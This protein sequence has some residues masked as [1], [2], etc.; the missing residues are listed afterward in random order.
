[1]C[2][3]CR[4]VSTSLNTKKTSTTKR[5]K[6]INKL[7]TDKRERN[8]RMQRKTMDEKVTQD[9]DDESEL[10]STRRGCATNTELLGQ[11]YYAMTELYPS[12]EPDRK[13]CDKH[14]QEI[15][16]K[17]GEKHV[18][19]TSEFAKI[20]ADVEHGLVPF[21]MRG[22]GSRWLS[23]IQCLMIMLC[24][25]IVFIVCVAPI[26]FSLKHAVTGDS[27]KHDQFSVIGN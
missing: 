8:K 9:F 20:E 2:L 5:T 24:F 22:R 3:T 27:E 26:F 16:E 11:E 10:L 21:K 13:I 1:M 23:N 12:K 15:E 19:V 25:L 18:L 6:K 14:S 4:L 7:K 17:E